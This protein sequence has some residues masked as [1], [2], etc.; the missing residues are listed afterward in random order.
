MITYQVKLAHYAQVG[1]KEKLK[2]RIAVHLELESIGDQWIPSQRDNKVEIF[3]CCF[4]RLQ[5]K[6]L[7]SNEWHKIKAM[8]I[9]EI[10][11]YILIYGHHCQNISVQY[12][13]TIIITIII[14][15]SGISL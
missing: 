13:I 7:L 4:A 15:T 1:I 10:Y 11:V 9:Y 3:P 12:I 5:K 14:M 6:T 8:L 2:F